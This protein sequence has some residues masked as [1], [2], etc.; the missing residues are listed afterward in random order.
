[1]L[2]AAEEHQQMS[3]SIKGQEQELNARTSDRDQKQSEIQSLTQ[4]I[5]RLTQRQTK[6]RESIVV[7]AQMNSISPSLREQEHQA[8]LIEGAL[9]ESQSRKSPLVTELQSITRSQ[10]DAT[11]RLARL[12]AQLT[13]LDEL[14]SSSATSLQ[15][16]Q[17]RPS[18]QQELR[19]T[20][21]KLIDQQ[22]V[23]T[24]AMAQLAGLREELRRVSMTLRQVLTEFSEYFR[25]VEPAC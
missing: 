7:V 8:S 3:I 20:R 15:L 10:I 23:K 22:A 25:C 18:L 11:E 16:L 4:Q 1:M 6:L 13:L 9:T 5:Q 12:R 21:Q 17:E 24:S 14:E 2:A 19:F